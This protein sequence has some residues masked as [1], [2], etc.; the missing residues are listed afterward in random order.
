MKDTS[1]QQE[2]NK[3]V[4]GQRAI[5]SCLLALQ[6]MNDKVDVGLRE[7]SQHAVDD[8]LSTIKGNAPLLTMYEGMKKEEAS[9]TN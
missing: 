2:I 1:V 8:L 5:L 7:T 3:H 4:A 9:Q 6:K